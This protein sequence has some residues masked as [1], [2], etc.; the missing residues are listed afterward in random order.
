[1]NKDVV[2][3]F[4]GTAVDD[5]DDFTRLIRSSRPG[6]QASIT[7]W[8]DGES[9]EVKA[10]LASVRDA[11][12]GWFSWSD[13]DDSDTPTPATPPAMPAPPAPPN[14]RNFSWSSEGHGH[15]GVYL[16]DLNKDISS[17]FSVP[18][19]HGALVW[20]VVDNSPAEDAGLKAGDVIVSVQDKPV[21][22]SQD[23]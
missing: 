9:M 1:R 21:R 14:V 19:A 23:L 17:F 13:G 16:Q 22:D 15:M 20:Q 11:R 2:T 7:V 10:T 3:R 5:E 8:R 4:N 6:S 18:D 12:K